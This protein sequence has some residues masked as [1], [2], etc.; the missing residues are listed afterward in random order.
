MSV[1]VRYTHVNKRGFTVQIDGQ[2]YKLDAGQVELTLPDQAAADALIDMHPR[3]FE[4]VAPD[5]PRAPA[6]PKNGA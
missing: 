2:I 6:R 4:V 1:I 5:P 3:A